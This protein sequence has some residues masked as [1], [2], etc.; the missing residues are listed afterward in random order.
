MSNLFLPILEVIQP[1]RFSLYILFVSERFIIESIIFPSSNFIF[2]YV[3]V[4]IVIIHGHSPPF[5]RIQKSAPINRDGFF[6]RY[7]PNCHIDH[8]SPDNGR[9]RLLLLIITFKATLTGV[10][11]SCG[12]ATFPK[13]P[14]ALCRPLHHVLFLIITFLYLQSILTPQLIKRKLFLKH[15]GFITPNFF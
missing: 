9:Y 7:H 15:S 8:L 12:I 3:I 13:Q 14:A 4:V 11:P 10:F 6:P 1:F 5:K 2:I